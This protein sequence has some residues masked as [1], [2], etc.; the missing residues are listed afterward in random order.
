MRIE[1]IQWKNLFAYGDKVNEIDYSNF[2][3]LIL[4]TGVS[5]S[6]KSSILNLPILLLYGKIEKVPKNSIAN[7]INKNGW[8][9]GTVV[10]GQN[11]Y[12][13]ERTF[14]PNSVRVWKDGTNIENYGIKDAQ[15]YINK[16]VIEIPQSTFANLITISFKKF[17]SFLTMSPYDRKQIIDRVFNLEVINIVYENL[18][19]DATEIGNTINSDNSTLYSLGITLKNATAELAKLNSQN[20]VEEEKNKI[21]ENLKSIE[22]VQK[23]I[24]EYSEGY[25][26]VQNKSNEIS[27]QFNQV[28]KEEIKIDL[29][30]KNI[31]S[32]IELFNKDKCPLCGTSFS[33]AGF[34]SIKVSLNKLLEQKNQAKNTQA[35]L[36]A[37]LKQNKDKVSEYL[38]KMSNE[39]Y[40]LKLKI[41]DLTSS[42]TIIQNKI[43]SSSNYKSIQN[44]IDKTTE[45]IEDLKKNIEENNKKMYDLQNLQYVFSIDGVKQQVINN[46][47]PLM[48]EEMNKNLFKLNIQYRLEFDSKFNPHLYDLE[49]EIEI[50]TL[51]DGESTRVDVVV[52]CS[53]FKLLKRRYP[54]IN[55]FSADEIISSLDEINA[56]VVL[57]FLKDFCNEMK[58]NCIVVSHINLNQ[59]DFDEIIEVTKEKG[60]S[61]INKTKNANL[62]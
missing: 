22:I 35:E 48:N 12:T 62:Q 5:G 45:Q 38:G 40:N 19:K 46:Y 26:L 21:E 9:K 58:L 4:L 1:N 34:E 28:K 51:S 2:G 39:M 41:K 6:G 17:K 24:S 61:Q 54:S 56:K 13:I 23:K 36:L 18:K 29:D 52:L 20:N 44:I 32:K 7:R 57:K 59:E 27:E 10:K 55:L 8:I 60:F 31:K 14:L 47:I 49:N 33:S 50:E 30:I 11:T 37:S 16:N 25:S 53:L 43:K 3:K 42:N 15:D